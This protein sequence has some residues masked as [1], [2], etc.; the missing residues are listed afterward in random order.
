MALL[1][2]A[3]CAAIEFP[4]GL[5]NVTRSTD[6]SELSAAGVTHIIPNGDKSSVAQSAHAH[7]IGIIDLPDSGEPPSARP[8]PIAAWYIADEPEINRQSPA[9]IAALSAK[10]RERDPRIPR[11]LV[12]GTGKFAS[13]YAESVDFLMVDWYPV[14]HLPLRSLGDNIAEAKA[15]SGGTPIWAVV[16]AMDWRDY[17][18]RNPHKPR[19]G[20]FPSRSEIR[21]MAFHAISSGASG[22]F[23]FEFQ[24]RPMPGKTIFDSPEHWQSL[25]SVLQELR[26]LR[27]FFA[28]G[29]KEFEKMGE[30][31]WS[32]WE[33]EGSAVA[34][35][36]NPT[37]K[38]QPV[39]DG[40]FGHQWHLFSAGPRADQDGLQADGQLSAHGLVWLKR[41]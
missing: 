23:F 30:V 3:S 19:I 25:K 6:I 37:D 13:G 24:R 39:P 18:Q 38:P 11:V 10:V 27:R 9:A 7:G 2:G 40:I 8:Y 28:L 41:G 17:P 21:F 5:Y 14:P 12:I 36:L 29:R 34:L 4:I 15:L 33:S 22:I 31:E 20:R 16:Q 26:F 32:V 1:S 35:L